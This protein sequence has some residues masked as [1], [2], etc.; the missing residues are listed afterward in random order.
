V[1]LRCFCSFL[2]SRERN[3]DVRDKEL[4]YIAITTAII[5]RLATTTATKWQLLLQLSKDWQLI[6]K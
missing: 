6:L 4:I 5:E 3:K 2:S 1:S